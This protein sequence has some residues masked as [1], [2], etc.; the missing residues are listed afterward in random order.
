MKALSILTTIVVSSLILNA[1]PTHAGDQWVVYEGKSGPGVGKHIV[2]ISGDDEYRSEEALP[3]LGKILA[4]HHGFKCTVLFAIN[5]E[6]GTITPNY[7][8][9]I[10][11]MHHLD[12]ADLAILSLRFRQLPDDQMKHFVDFV[13]AGKP[14]IGLRT[15]THAF[16]YDKDSASKYAHYGWRNSKWRGGFGQ[17]VLGDT[18][19][20]H[21]GR[22]K[23]ESTRGIINEE[24]ADHPILNGVEDIWGPTDVYGIRNL[25]ETATVLVKGQVL[26]GMQ[27][28]DPP[29]E[30]EKNDPMMPL[31][32]TREY[33][34]EDGT[35]NRVFCTTMGASTD[36]LSEGLRRLI[37]N[38]SYW[39][40]E[41]E[42][43]IPAE[44]NVAIVGEYEPITYG[45]NAFKKGLVPSDFAWSED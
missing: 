18:W 10:P 14:I 12:D 8:R 17:Q 28:T 1:N 35:T 32:W 16:N 9:N 5:P 44:S 21:H 29:V 33:K 23:S 30:G 34:A 42:A 11:G 6:D 45:F 41:M 22:H 39:A 15:S 36:L 37:V 7:Q 4:Q 24:H 25:P 38:A 27:P 19:I 31:A 40:L 43:Q 2:L 20:S 13:E 26:Q 3:Q